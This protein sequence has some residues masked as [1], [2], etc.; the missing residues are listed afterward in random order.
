MLAR[1]WST[2]RK[3][4]EVPDCV[5]IV[6]QKDSNTGQLGKVK[7]L[8]GKDRVVVKLRTGSE[9]GRLKEYSKADLKHLPALLDKV[10][11]VDNRR[12]QKMAS[13]HI[14]K[15]IVVAI[16]CAVVVM[17]MA[18]FGIA[19][20]TKAVDTDGTTL[21][22]AHTDGAVPLQVASV[23]SVVDKY[24]VLRG[25]GSDRA[26][27]VELAE[28]YIPLTDLPKLTEE[29]LDKVSELGFATQDGVW[30]AYHRAAVRSQG[31]GAGRS[32]EVVTSVPGLSVLINATAASLCF[33]CD[34]FASPLGS[35]AGKRRAIVVHDR[36]EL[37]DGRRALRAGAGSDLHARCHDNGACLHTREEMIA[38]RGGTTRR[39]GRE[40]EKNGGKMPWVALT[41]AFGSGGASL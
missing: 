3:E 24:N 34:V 36:A 21:L 25:R 5:E 28:V 35:G 9:R 19:S 17:G 2:V 26:V 8:I 16:A 22:A 40:A 6:R 23:D 12:F 29:E 33:G 30:H 31:D 1:L 14:V 37:E 13:R 15:T 11:E 10:Q 7:R 38:L 27:R 32:V 4:F 20:G 39:L 18:T 41:G